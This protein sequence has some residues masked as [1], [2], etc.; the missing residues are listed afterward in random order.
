MNDSRC[1]DPKPT[2][3]EERQDSDI[4]LSYFFAEV[5][6]QNRSQFYVPKPGLSVKRNAMVWLGLDA[7]LGSHLWAEFKR[8]GAEFIA[9]KWLRTFLL[10]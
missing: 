6:F 4:R 2:H 8:L 9:E 5:G 3:R 1:L 7:G 10:G